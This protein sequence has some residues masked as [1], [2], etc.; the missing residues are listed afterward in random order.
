MYPSTSILCRIPPALPWLMFTRAGI[1]TVVGTDSPQSGKPCRGSR[2]N[3]NHV[4][5]RQPGSTRGPAEELVS[6]DVHVWWH[7]LVLVLEYLLPLP[8]DPFQALA[9]P[10]HACTTSNPSA[11]SDRPASPS[12]LCSLGPGK[13]RH[14]R[15]ANKRRVKVDGCEGLSASNT[16]CAQDPKRL[17]VSASHLRECGPHDCGMWCVFVAITNPASRYSC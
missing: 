13:G 1:L 11:V 3:C 12:P 10:R 2:R 5:E 9:H 17:T 16:A 15:I 14:T 7:G 8:I 6:L 4:C